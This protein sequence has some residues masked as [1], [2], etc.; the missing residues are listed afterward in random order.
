MCMWR[1][2]NDKTARAAEPDGGKT[3]LDVKLA[4]FFE[5]EIHVGIQ[6]GV[7]HGGAQL[8]VHRCTASQYNTTVN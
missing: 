6:Q 2:G 4:P 3:C 5:D 8:N 1:H 7:V